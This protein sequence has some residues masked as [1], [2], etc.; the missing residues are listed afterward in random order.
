MSSWIGPPPHILPP[1]K[2][3]P[4]AVAVLRSIALLLL[5]C[6]CLA[7]FIPLRVLRR[8]GPSAWL[9]PVLSRF[10][11]RA[12]LYVL[13]IDFERRGVPLEQGAIVVANHC[14]WLDIFA[15]RTGPF[16]TFIAKDDVASWPVIGAVARLNGTMFVARRRSAAGR[17]EKEMKERLSRGEQLVFFPEG[18][19]SDSRRV[20]PFKSALFAAVCKPPLQE[21]TLVQPVSVCWIAPPGQPD[22]FFGWWGSMGLA[23]SLWAV[24]SRARGGRL[25]LTWHP[26]LHPDAFSDRKRLAAAAET[27]VAEGLIASGISPL[28]RGEEAWK[29]V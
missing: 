20:L 23:S 8:F 14:S 21:N 3:W 22:T 7:L 15:L 18:T 11:A 19:S 9:I 1:L 28:P 4:R 16:V 26:P 13:G 5:T 12:G 2:L 27:L 24:V 29:A 10:W 6:V 17:Q 25:I